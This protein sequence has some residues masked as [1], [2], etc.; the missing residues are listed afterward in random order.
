MLHI[1]LQ[2]FKLKSSWSDRQV[3][4]QPHSSLV[5]CTQSLA[6]SL[7]FQYLKPSSKK[8]KK[9]NLH[10]SN[11]SLHLQLCWLLLPPHLSSRDLWPPKLA[12]QRLR[13]R[14]IPF[15][16]VRV[17]QY[18]NF[19]KGN[20]LGKQ[21]KNKT[22]EREGEREKEYKSLGKDALQSP[23]SLSWDNYTLT[24]DWLGWP[25]W[26]GSQDMKI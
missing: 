16:L 2:H 14:Q 17:R 25:N 8:K 15:P 23:K 24:A 5:R 18:W 13:C 4:R 6:K 3:S 22:R 11:P 1:P 9:A 7:S 21:V 19:S 26:Q 10:S 12:L 20:L